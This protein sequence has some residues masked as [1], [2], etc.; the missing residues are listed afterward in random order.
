LLIRALLNDLH[1]FVLSS[2]IGQ[3]GILSAFYIH[4]SFSTRPQYGSLSLSLVH[5][6]V[7]VKG[8]D[9]ALKSLYASALC[10]IVL[11]VFLCH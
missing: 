2:T 4:P 5:L 11:E 1:C 3:G 9:V 8:V 7:A 10:F 6:D